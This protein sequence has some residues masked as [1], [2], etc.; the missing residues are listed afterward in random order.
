M[1]SN[2]EDNGYKYLREYDFPSITTE[3]LSLIHA[4]DSFEDIPCQIV[5]S[6]LMILFLTARLLHANFIVESHNA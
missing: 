3:L 6:N 2:Y 1:A 4:S 5:F